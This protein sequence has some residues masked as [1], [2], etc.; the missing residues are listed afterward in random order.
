MSSFRIRHR[1]ELAKEW[2][3]ESI[4]YPDEFAAQTVA[5]LSCVAPGRVVEIID[6]QDKTVWPSEKVKMAGGGA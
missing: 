5:E 1:S 3:T 6:E 4:E 2:I